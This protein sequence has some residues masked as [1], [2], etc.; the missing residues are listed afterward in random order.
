MPVATHPQLS[1]T[2]WTDLTQPCPVLIGY[3][4]RA[5]IPAEVLW[6]SSQPVPAIGARVHVHTNG[7]GGAEV[8][9]YFHFDGFLGVI[10]ALDQ[11]P[12]HLRAAGTTLGHVYGRDL[13]PRQAPAAPLA[14]CSLDWIPEYP[15]AGAEP[16]AYFRH[17]GSEQLTVVR[18]ELA[19]YYRLAGLEVFIGEDRFDAAQLADGR[20]WE[21]FGVDQYLEVPAEGEPRLFEAVQHER[22]W[23]FEQTY[24]YVGPYRMPGEQ[25]FSASD[26]PTTYLDLAA[27]AAEMGQRTAD[28]TGRLCLVGSSL[29]WFPFEEE[30]G[31][32]GYDYP[33][34]RVALDLAPEPIDQYHYHTGERV[35]PAQGQGTATLWRAQ[36]EGGGYYVEVAP[37]HP[38]A[39]AFPYLVAVTER[40]LRSWWHFHLPAA[41]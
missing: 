9:A 10:V 22:Q 20:A 19:R 32:F 36:D 39:P 37:R 17:Q 15:E 41:A 6:S 2:P 40:Q 28:F 11:V 8:K 25:P 14:P 30:A 23:I 24:Q 26:A 5:G 27:L 12:A 34:Q 21:G 16:V 33:W 4:T 31:E 38:Q 18:G 29:H 3:P 35:E 1:P 7:L 13:E